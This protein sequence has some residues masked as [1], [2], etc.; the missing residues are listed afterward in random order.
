[1]GNRRRPAESARGAYQMGSLGWPELI[2][3]AVLVLVLFGARRLPEIGKGLGEGIRSFR[4]A[5]RGEEGERG[6][7]GRGGGSGGG[8]P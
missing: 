2:L 3:L 4:A 7:E 5:I 8:T 6:K 1:M